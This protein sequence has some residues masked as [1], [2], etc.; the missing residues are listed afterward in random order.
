[1]ITYNDIYEAARKERHSNQLQ[2]LSP[3]FVRDVAV[4]LKE[5]QEIAMK[6]GDVFS[7]MI[8]K[9]KKQLENATTLFRELLLL[10][11]KKI[12]NLVLVAAETGVSKKDFLNMFIFERNL[13]ESLMQ[14]VETSEAEFREIFNSRDDVGSLNTMVVFLE[15]VDNFMSMEGKEM[16]PYG[17]GDV[18]NLPNDICE[19]LIGDKKVKKV[20]M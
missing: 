5:K 18:A 10:R 19:I 8:I 3:T 16:G 4:Y 12:L 15:D 11:R 1:M 13:F 14:C 2:K 6:D 17:K 7:D 9:T 20:D